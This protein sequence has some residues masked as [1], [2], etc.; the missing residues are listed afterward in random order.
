VDGKANATCF[1]KFDPEDS[2]EIL[3]A[4]LN[5]S[6]SELLI[7]N[8]GKPWIVRPLFINSNDMHIVFEAGTE[9]SIVSRHS[10]I[11]HAAVRFPSESIRIP[12]SAHIYFTEQVLD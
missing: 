8:V 4:A 10:E 9:S 3:Q 12:K 7:Q 11:M 5:S 2:T 1:G 6:A